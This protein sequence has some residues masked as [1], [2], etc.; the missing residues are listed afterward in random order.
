[1]IQAA[2]AGIGIEAHEGKQA[3]LAADFSITQFS[4]VCRLLLVHG[5]YCYKRSCALSQFV[6]HRW[7]FFTVSGSGEVFEERA[8]IQWVT[9]FNKMPLT[10]FKGRLD[11]LSFAAV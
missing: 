4:H 1:M 6:M 8:R 10:D 3:S 2:H 7:V 9:I 5:R 11:K